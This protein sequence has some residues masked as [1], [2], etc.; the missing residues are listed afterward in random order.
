MG[1]AT[2]PALQDQAGADSALC[3]HLGQTLRPHFSSLKSYINS[4]FSVT[5]MLL[6]IIK[7]LVK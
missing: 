4:P 5:E 6:E 7:W 2:L 3:T 1:L